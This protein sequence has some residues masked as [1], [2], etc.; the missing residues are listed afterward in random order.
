VPEGREWRL[1]ED[2]EK[3]PNGTEGDL[4]AYGALG[5]DNENKIEAATVTDALQ[6]ARRGISGPYGRRILTPRRT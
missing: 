3:V 6:R 4:R 1:R 2:C 5:D